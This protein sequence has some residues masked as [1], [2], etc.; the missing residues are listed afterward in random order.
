MFW[1]AAAA[2]AAAPLAAST[3][4]WVV[5]ASRETVSP[6]LLAARPAP[7]SA[8]LWSQQI[9]TAAPSSGS[10]KL[11]RREAV[12]ILTVGGVPAGTFGETYDDDSKVDVEGAWSVHSDGSAEELRLRDVVSAQLAVP[13]FFTD[14]Y[15]LLFRPPRLAPGDTAAFALSRKSRRDVYQWILPLQREVPVVGQEVVVDLPEGWRHRWRLTRAP[16]GYEGPLSGEGGNRASYRFG[17]QR[18]LSPET[19]AP[20]EADRAAHVEVAI[21]PP[22]GARSDLAFGSWNDVASWFERKSAAARGDAPASVRIGGPDGVAE[23][24]RWVQDRIRYVALEV[25]EGGYA[26]RPPALVAQRLFGDCKDKAFLT[27]AL[28]KRLGVDAYP[29]LAL[30][31][32]FGSVDPDFPTPAAFNHLIV[33]VH[34]PKGG[35]FPASVTLADGLLVIF[36]PTNSWTPFGEIDGDLQ[37]TRS[38]LVRNGTGVLLTLPYAPA[39]R[40]LH[41]R[42]VDATLDSDGRLSAVVKDT[43]EGAVSER[44]Y[45]REMTGL[46]RSEAIARR[47]ERQI[48][49]SSVSLA[50][51]AHLDE[52]EVPFEST[53]TVIAPDF[54]RRAGSISLLP[55]LPCPIGPGRIPR[56]SERRSPIDLGPPRRVELQT[57]IRLPPGLSIEGMPEPAEADTPYAAYRFA[58]SRKGDAIVATESFEVR[59]PLIPLADVSAWKPV[60]A[61]ASRARAATLAVLGR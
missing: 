49:G 22:A 7:E 16:E 44:G 19:D 26:A 61:A 47:A 32:E 39:G 56:L 4:D 53:Y 57:T 29:V 25:G 2:A 38:L 15:R 34:L 31:R 11:F 45:F 23:A 36:D 55:V 6:G 27:I 52:R 3:P 9:I 54:L 43:T 17:P 50:S 46:E 48:P 1:L 14:T 42:V 13:E 51:F 37:G 41:R 20:P 18:A 59:K 58:V 30:P 35:S 8:V 33:A 12:R 21:L 28:L 40:N 5:R 60:E 24:A 10:T